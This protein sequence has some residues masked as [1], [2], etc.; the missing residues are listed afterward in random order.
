M[1]ATTIVLRL[2]H[3]FTGVFWAGTVFLLARF[4]LP[5]VRASG[6]AGDKVVQQLFLRKIG[7][8]IPASAVLAVLSG[9]TMYWRNNAASSGAWAASRPG[10]VYGVGGAAALVA[11]VLGAAIIGP[12]LE[13]VVKIQLAAEAASRALT[14]DETATIGMLKARSGKMTGIAAML[15]AI[16][17]AA[18]AIGRYM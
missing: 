17:V 7:V 11:L 16:T 10:A 2:I 9:M 4:L 8:A 5:S 12:S 6:P 15:L 13:K 18:M 3:V 1:G 14:A